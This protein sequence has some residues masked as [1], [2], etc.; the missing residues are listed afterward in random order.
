M[1]MSQ[2]PPERL[3]DFARR[4]V[5]YEAARAGRP[6]DVTTGF[7][8]ACR[9]LHDRLAPLISSSGFHTL[10]AR[11]LK[12]AARDFPVLATVTVSPNHDCTL[13]GL[14]GAADARDPAEAADAFALALGHFMWLLV[15]FIG[16]DLG[17]RTVRDVWPEVPL[18]RVT[19]F[20]E[21]GQ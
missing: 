4:L 20:S 18:D 11:A 8:R 9:A 14:D 16:E 19:P 13:S 6:D 5:R 17:L 21:A 1:V 10:F 2:R 7:E 3:S 12:L 15:I